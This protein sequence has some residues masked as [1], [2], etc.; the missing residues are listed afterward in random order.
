LTQIQKEDLEDD[1]AHPDG[2]DEGELKP[3]VDRRLALECL[4]AGATRLDI[5]H[6]LEFVRCVDP[7]MM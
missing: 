6:S 5:Y 4:Q 3:R 2:I 1:S 7:R